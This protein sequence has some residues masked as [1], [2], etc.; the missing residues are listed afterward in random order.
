M[1]WPL[2]QLLF[3]LGVFDVL[4]FVGFCVCECVSCLFSFYYTFTKYC[5][6]VF[7]PPFLVIILQYH[8]DVDVKKSANSGLKF[9][10]MTI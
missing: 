5:L 9:K 4:V 1:A 8:K 3:S 6:R 10:T 7:I 2:L